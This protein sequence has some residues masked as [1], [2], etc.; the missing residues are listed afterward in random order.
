MKKLH[1]IYRLKVLK[2]RQAS[3]YLLFCLI[4]SCE[5]RVELDQYDINFW[6]KKKV[7]IYRYE[8]TSDLC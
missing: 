7:V 2:S 6:K 1:T 5:S 3:V 4:T 8:E